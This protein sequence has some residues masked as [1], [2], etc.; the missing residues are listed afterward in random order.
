[1]QDSGASAEEN[2]EASRDAKEERKPGTGYRVETQHFVALCTTRNHSLPVHRKL[3]TS[4]VLL[5]FKDFSLHKA[6][7]W[8]KGGSMSITYTSIMQSF[9]TLIHCLSLLSQPTPF[10]GSSV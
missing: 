6:I 10:K 1:M 9:S 2:G 5:Q 4:T 3:Y 7:L 8:G